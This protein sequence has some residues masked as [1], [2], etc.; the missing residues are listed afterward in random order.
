MVNR[1]LLSFS[2]KLANWYYSASAP[3]ANINTEVELIAAPPRPGF[4]RAPGLTCPQGLPLFNAE[5]SVV[6]SLVHLSDWV[7]ST[8][9]PFKIGIA[10]RRATTPAPGQ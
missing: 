2:G 6:D 8:A 9:L 7:R 3:Q 5:T 4:D 1:S 10:S